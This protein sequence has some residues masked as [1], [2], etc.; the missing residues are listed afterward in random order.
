MLLGCA[1]GPGAAVDPRGMS[2]TTSSSATPST[3][4][5]S[6][7]AP[8]PAERPPVVVL[9]PG[10]NGGNT[11]APGEINRQVPAGRGRY[12]ACNTTGTATDGGYAE[13]A[14]NFDVAG[15]VRSALVERSVRVAL[16][17]PDDSGV[18]PCVNQRAAIGNEHGADAVVSIH[19]DGH[20]NAAATGFHI[21]YSAPALNDAQGAPAIRL[22]H[23]MRDALSSAGFPISSYLGSAG[24]SP[25]DDLGG[26]NLSERP[27]VL[28]E[29]GNMRNAGEAA[30]MS[31]PAGRQR[32]A[33]AITDGILRYLGV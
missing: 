13:H 2:V 26:L 5:S 11:G 23:A 19:A 1:T 18:G 30:E 31:T 17:R 3:T 9:D 27:A 28:V 7:P 4:E 6:A 10:H 12:K 33:D 22:A 14:F 15:R 29:C 32:Y 21:A 8:T 20:A 25:R 16:T 24:L